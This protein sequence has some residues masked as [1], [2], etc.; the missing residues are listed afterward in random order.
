MFLGS[1]F[2]GFTVQALGMNGSTD[3]SLHLVVQNADCSDI[4]QYCISEAYQYS[5]PRTS[6][7]DTHM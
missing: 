2:A 3:T 1:G 7:I 4:V 6:L 5:M